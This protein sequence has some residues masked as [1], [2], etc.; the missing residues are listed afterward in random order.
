MTSSDW[1]EGTTP[2]GKKYYYHRVTRESVWTKPD[3]SKNQQQNN[4]PSSS[5]SSTAASGVAWKEYTTESGKKYYHNPRTNETRW[6]M[7]AELAHASTWSFEKAQKAIINDERYQALKTMGER[8]AAFQDYLSERKKY[9]YEEKKKKDKRNREE[10]IKLLKESTEVLST[11]TWRRAVLY[12]D[13]DPRWDAVE[14]EREREE[15]FKGYMTELERREKDI[16]ESLKRDLMKQ[17]RSTFES[18]PNITSKSQWRKVKDEYEGDMLFQ[19]VDKLDVLTI[20]EGYIRDLEKKES[21]IQRSDRERLKRE[22]RK[23]R[24]NFREFLNEKTLSGDLCVST[25]WKDFYQKFGT[26]PVFENLASQTTGSSPL[27]LFSDHMEELE[28]RYDKD[29]KRLEDIVEKLNYVYSQENSTLESFIELITKHEKNPLSLKEREEK[30]AKNSVKKKSISI[31]NFKSLL[32]DTRS[33][34]KHSTWQEV[35]PMIRRDP[36]FQELD[37][38]AERESIFK[39]YI[40]YIANEESDEEGI[41]KSDEGEDNQRSRKEFSR[42]RSSTPA[43]DLDD[44]KKKVERR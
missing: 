44:R 5:G 34:N 2:D 9:E 6:D 3:E 26:L 37:D 14:H 30:R 41:I 31:V 35:I 25:K 7:P 36:A 27:E 24:D 32:E 40:D 21:D 18:N 33:I 1:I 43:Y 23:H 42:K 10:F 8:K 12:F 29:F 28:I 22:A 39:E 4:T 13:G 19:N 15:L 38:E 20:F 11:M 17:I 16:R